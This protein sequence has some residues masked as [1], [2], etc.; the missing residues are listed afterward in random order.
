MGHNSLR[1]Y[2]LL[3]KGN[4]QKVYFKVEYGKAKT[5]SGKMEMF[6]NEAVCSDPKDAYKTFKAFWE[7]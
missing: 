2:I 4:Y 1:M 3:K 7:L 5:T 6:Y